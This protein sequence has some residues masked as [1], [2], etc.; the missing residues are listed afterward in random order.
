MAEGFENCVKAG[1]RVRRVDGPN[2]QHG[3]SAIQYVE[4][5]H[6]RGRTYRGGV[7]SIL[8]DFLKSRPATLLETGSLLLDGEGR[9]PLD[10]RGRRRRLNK[11]RLLALPRAGRLT[12]GKTTV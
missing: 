3:L 6:R 10:S 2:E 7:R 11:I 1:G 4:Y 9:V 12:V 5:C 8:D